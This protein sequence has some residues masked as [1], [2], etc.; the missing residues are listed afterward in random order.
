MEKVP[1]M[2]L[3]GLTLLLA[4]LG[5]SIAAANSPEQV[6]AR[7]SPSVVVVQAGSQQGSGVIIAPNLV[8]TN[9]HVIGAADQIVV[10]R[11]RQS[12]GAR[13][14]FGDLDR[15]ICLLQVP[16]LQGG[17]AVLGQ[18]ANAR[19]G[20]SV[21]AIGAPRGLEL[22]LSAGLISQLREANAG[23]IIQTTAPISPGSSGGGLFDQRGRLIGIT[24]FQLR[25]GQNI[26]FAVPVEWITS[27]TQRY[28]TEQRNWRSCRSSPQTNCLMAAAVTLSLFLTS[29]TVDR[30][31]VFSE[32]HLLEAIGK[33]QLELGDLDA[34]T[35]TL[36]R[37]VRTQAIPRTSE[38]IKFYPPG[39]DLRCALTSTLARRG[40]FDEAQHI[41]L[42]TGRHCAA[43]LIDV[44]IQLGQWT[45]VLD[46]INKIERDQYY[47]GPQIQRQQYIAGVQSRIGNS[48][49]AISLLKAT[50]QLVLRTSDSW[51]R[52]HGLSELAEHQFKAG[53]SLGAFETIGLI[54]EAWTKESA[55]TDIALTM[56]EAGN[57]V[58]ARQIISQISDSARR[59]IWF[60]RIS[61]LISE[62]N[63][64]IQSRLFL[65]YAL[66]EMRS[67]SRDRS[68]DPHEVARPKR[69]LSEALAK[70]GDLDE[71][72]ALARS[73]PRDMRLRVSALSRVARIHAEM[74]KRSEAIALLREAGREAAAL[75]TRNRSDDLVKEIISSLVHLDDMQEALLLTNA[76]D[77][78]DESLQEISHAQAVLQQFLSATATVNRI[79]NLSKRNQA[80]MSILSIRVQ[81]GERGLTGTVLDTLRRVEDPSSRYE[82]VRVHAHSLM[83][84]DN[85]G[86]AM[87]F[88][89]TLSGEVERGIALAQMA[90]TL[91]K[92]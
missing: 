23:P 64:A 71:A 59:S 81:K 18:A 84:S 57:F 55:R 82:A 16:S 37:L 66:D 60:S 76:L 36:D 61:I 39:H 24:T 91:H 70:H 9:C 38:W 86:E 68:A 49:E 43:E 29:N 6:F 28:E 26:N 22:S 20:A 33:A 25:E 54:G 34:A 44:L 2:R 63:N 7:A 31:G 42:H 52:D 73:M 35:E 88:V 89:E 46:L 87:Q 5:P 62:K 1:A 67:L 19:I 11:S 3:L 15:D 74:G 72:L 56:A 65:Q 92:R 58:S 77:S 12:H 51:R 4:C 45:L 41:A 90:V 14:A 69:L 47:L 40:D 50:R 13:R 83:L 30:E 21:F 85:S 17:I 53:D 75:D 27:L 48:E 10:R 78:P 8:V 32:E 79:R 80:S